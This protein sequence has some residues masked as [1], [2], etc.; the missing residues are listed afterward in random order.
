MQMARASERTL[1]TTSGLDVVSCAKFVFLST[2]KLTFLILIADLSTSEERNE[3][4]EGSGVM[5]P[6][7][8]YRLPFLAMVV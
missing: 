4:Q 5:L 3:G 7:G 8:N 6:L 1:L 2:I